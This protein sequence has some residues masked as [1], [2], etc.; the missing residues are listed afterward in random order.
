[1]KR[2]MEPATRK[3]EEKI[4]QYHIKT[5]YHRSFL[6]LS[7]MSIFFCFSSV[8]SFDRCN[9]SWGWNDSQREAGKWAWEH[10]KCFIAIITQSLIF[11]SQI[12]LLSKWLK[13]SLL[14][15]LHN[16]PYF[17]QQRHPT[18]TN[19]LQS[20]KKLFHPYN[21]SDTL[22]GELSRKNSEKKWR[23]VSNSKQQTTRKRE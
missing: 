4:N 10:G 11:F 12:L 19:F 14:L 23:T 13:E 22:V 7:S 20:R 1:M 5:F 17:F 2:I 3:G 8:L 16:F 6:Y 15:S 9:K 21:S 18:P